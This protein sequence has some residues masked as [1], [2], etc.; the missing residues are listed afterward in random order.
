MAL[1]A[2]GVKSKPKSFT[3]KRLTGRLSE[4]DP[5][6]RRHSIAVAAILVVTIIHFAPLLSGR[7][8]SMVGAHMYAQYPWTAYAK[9]DPDIV[10][11]G[12]PQTD[13]AET[14]YPANVFATNALRSGQFPMWSPYSFGGIPLVEV[15]LGT[16]L[17]YPP[18]LLAS[19]ILSPIDQHDFIL[20]THCLLAGL[21]MYAL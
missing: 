7:S 2:S 13:H 10:G 20:F 14:F 17:L 5:E 8:F 15:G 12:Y 16:G 21:G 19:L 6:N 1:P 11:R 4:I 18:K 9:P 3:L